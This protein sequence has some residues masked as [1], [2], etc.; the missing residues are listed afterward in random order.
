MAQLWSIWK[1]GYTPFQ[2]VGADT[3][4]LATPN[5][6]LLW[7]ADPKVIHQLELQHPKSQVAVDMMSFYEIYGPTIGTVE[8]PEGAEWKR[9]RKVIM[10]AFT[11]STNSAVWSVTTRQ[12]RAL[13]DCWL[14]QGGKV[15]VMKDWTCRLALHVISAVFFNKNIT[16]DSY[17]GHAE[18]IPDGH[19]LSYQD[20]LFTVLA[21]LGT[22]YITPPA[23]RGAIPFGRVQEVNLAFNEWT[24]YMQELQG[25]AFAR[26]DEIST[27]KNRTILGT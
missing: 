8:G 14:H 20:S 24:Q 4:M 12:T 21:R 17:T 26:I 15:Q 23:I 19:K 13:V 6:N 7:S 27:K 16:W 5:G 1:I 18:A 10:S 11:P 22:L 2:D 9:H 3:F 25:D